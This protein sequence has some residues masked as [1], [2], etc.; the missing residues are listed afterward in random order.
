MTGL[1]TTTGLSFPE[2]WI[3]SEE[4]QKSFGD[5]LQIAYSKLLVMPE[6]FDAYNLLHR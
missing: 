5:W 6:P 2:S 3:L 1:A 4:M